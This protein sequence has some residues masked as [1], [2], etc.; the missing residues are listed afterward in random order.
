MA[1]TFDNQTVE[2]HV[3]SLLRQ[4]RYQL[5]LTPDM[6][7]VAYYGQLRQAAVKLDGYAPFGRIAVDVLAVGAE[8]AVNGTETAY[9]GAIYA[10][11]GAYPKLKVGVDGI[12]NEYGEGVA[13]FGRKGCE[14]IGKFLHGE[15]I[16]RRTCPNPQHVN[17]GLKGLF[18][19]P[20][21]G[22]FGSGEHTG[23]LLHLA[24][25]CK[26]RRTDSFKTA[27]LCTRL[28]HA[29]SEYFYALFYQSM[30]GFKYLC[31]ALGAARAGEYYGAVAEKLGV[32]QW[33]QI[34]YRHVCILLSASFN[35]FSGAQSDMR[36]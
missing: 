34:C 22:Y 24:E 13:A 18:K 21:I 7:G 23:F 5:T 4:R 25:P 27:G 30:S 9:A 17:T 10:L 16:G 35:L 1:V 26:R 28:P 32:E 6:A 2:I 31:L 20:G 29:G 3:E 14:H 12:L 11:Q 19:M 15:R 8:S 36:I 33:F